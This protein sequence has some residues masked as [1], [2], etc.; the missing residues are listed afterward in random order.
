M[1]EGGETLRCKG[2]FSQHLIH[3]KQFQ[4]TD[5]QMEIPKTE[6]GIEKYLGSGL[7]KGV[8]PKVAEKIVQRFKKETLSIIETNPDKLLEIRGLGEKP[9]R[10]DQNLV[11]RT[12]SH[13]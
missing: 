3:G 9:T 8:G 6:K 2:T 4:V 13:L 11:E 7:I 5:Y 12:K 10:Q 1:L